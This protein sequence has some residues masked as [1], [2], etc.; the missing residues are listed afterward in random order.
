M[1]NHE[2]I[3]TLFTNAIQNE[4]NQSILS[5]SYNKIEYRKHSILL[6]M[7]LLSLKKKLKDYRHV[8]ELHEFQIGRYIRWINLSNQSFTNGGFIVRIDIEENGSIIT[9]KNG[10]NVFFKLKVDECIVFQKITQQEHILLA[11][12]E[13]I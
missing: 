1:T 8:D 6:E 4:Y 7:K 3:S 11:A 13:H 5:L 2:T 10:V 9:C 12:M